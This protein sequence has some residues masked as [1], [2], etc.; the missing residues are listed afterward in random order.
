MQQTRLSSCK[1]IICKS[2]GGRTES[3]TTEVTQQQQQQQTVFYDK[4]DLITDLFS[5]NSFSVAVLVHENSV[6]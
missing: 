3:D 2:L 6:K 4:S 5:V 1:L